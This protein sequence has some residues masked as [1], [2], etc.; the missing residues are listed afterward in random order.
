MRETQ[1]IARR[2]EQTLDWM[3]DGTRRL[4]AG[5]EN[6]PDDAL[7]ASTMLPGWDRR[8][9]LSHVA[10]NAEALRNLVHW[11]RT[12]EERRMYASAAAREE[13]IKAG[14]AKPTGELRAW[15]T[16]SAAALADDLDTLPDH[17]WEA[18]ILTAQGLTRTA[19]E[20]PWMRVREVYV[21]TVDLDTGTGFGDLPAGFLAALCDDIAQRRSVVGTSPALA[22]TDAGTGRGWAVSGAAAPET[23]G[24]VTV[25]APLADLTAWLAGR[26]VTGLTDADGRPVPDLPAWL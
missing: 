17:A 21:H 4:L 1:L 3:R 13:G 9:L 18:T 24:P 22:L 25:T 2:P 15:I 12:G 26:P 7:A 14:T 8:Y 10:A 11:A 20:I 16:E 6:L 5:I 23:D 19:S